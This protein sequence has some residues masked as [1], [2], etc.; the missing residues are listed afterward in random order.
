MDINIEKINLT[1]ARIMC[2]LAVAAPCNNLKQ[3]LIISAY[4]ILTGED[5]E[6]KATTLPE[7]H[8][9]NTPTVSKTQ[10]L[11]KKTT[12]TT[13]T[14]KEI[15]REFIKLFGEQ[16][17]V[18]QESSKIYEAYKE[19]C[20]ERYYK[21]IPLANFALFIKQVSKLVI[22]QRNLKRVFILPLDKLNSHA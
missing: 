12:K 5:M 4:K 13:K 22:A 16:N 6:V 11:S 3:E 19:Y 2:E 20:D 10:K 7:I 18:N 14:N 8:T 9:S 21:V 1:K 17:I 15:V